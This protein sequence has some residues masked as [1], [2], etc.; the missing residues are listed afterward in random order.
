MLAEHTQYIPI[1]DS[2]ILAVR[3]RAGHVFNR[4]FEQIHPIERFYLGGASSIRGYERDYCPPFGLLTKPIH[5]PHAGLPPQAHDIWRYAPQGG[6]T[7]FNLNTELRC[8]VYI[9]FG[10]VAFSDF[11][12]LFQNSMHEEMLS[13]RCH[14]FAG[15]G[16][17]F[18]Y[19]TPIGAFRFDVGVKW[20]IQYKDFEAPYVVY[21]S[22]GQAF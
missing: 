21:L 6:R 19:D 10:I 12:A 8:G 5:D 20:K 11:G 4:C 16:L 2:I 7:M 22:L 3:A 18:R 15:S 1:V 9:G 13:K 14:T 17:G